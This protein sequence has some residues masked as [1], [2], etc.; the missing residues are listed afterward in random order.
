MQASDYLDLKV[1]YNAVVQGIIRFFVQGKTVLEI[2][3]AFG[4][5]DLSDERIAQLKQTYTWLDE[6]IPQEL[7]SR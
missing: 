5:V 3:H 4:F 1:V 2:Q 6:E 7:A